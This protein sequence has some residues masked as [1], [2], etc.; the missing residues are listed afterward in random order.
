M[1]DKN[2]AHIG[3]IEVNLNEVVRDPRGIEDIVSEVLEE[4]FIESRYRQFGAW[5]HMFPDAAD[6]ADWDSALLYRYPRLYTYSEDGCSDCELGPCNLSESTGRCGLS[7]ESWQGRMS[8]RKACRGCASQMEV[9]HEIL[10][11]AIKVWDEGKEVSF[12]KVM[13]ISDEVPP[14]G[15]LTGIH[16]KTLGDLN[17]VQSY[18]ETQMVKLLWASQAGTGSAAAFEGMAMHAGSVLMAAQAVSE[19]VKVSCYDFITAADQP[20]IELDNWPPATTDGGWASIEAEKPTIALLGD[21]FLPAWN[22]INYMKENELT[23]QIEICSIGAAG[24]DTARFYSR[25]RVIA[26][27]AKAE[28]A[29]R[30]GVFDVVLAT[31]GCMAL[32]LIGE[33]KRVDAKLVWVSSQSLGDLEDRTAQPVDEIVDALIGGESAVWL[34]DV[35]KAGEVAVKIA[36]KAK[37][38]GSYILSD[39]EA[40]AEA[41]KCQG[42]CDLCFS[43]CP[44][45]LPISRAVEQLEKGNWEGFSEVEKGCYFCAK[46]ENS[47]PS[48]VKLRDIIVATE[49]KR[50]DTDK[51]VMRAGRGVLPLTELLQSAFAV[52][53]GNAPGI[54]V[55]LGCGNAPQEEIAWIGYELT[56]RNCIVI[57]AGCGAAEIAR[58]QNPQNKFIS[59]EFVSSVEARAF[60]NCGSCSAT[61]LASTFYMIMNSAG[62]ISH[63]ASMPEIA[64]ASFRS[65]MTL[66][67]WGALTDRMYAIGAAYARLGYKVVVGPASGLEWNRYAMGNRHDRSR[68]WVYHSEDGS[69][70]ETEPAPEHFIV[71][72]ETKEEA[73]TMLS[74]LFMSPSEFRESRA[75]HL[76]T[77]IELYQI[78]YDQLPD[79]W[80]LLVRSH[81]EMPTRHR[82]K[83]LKMLREQY[84]WETGQGRVQKAKN[85]DG[86]LMTL[87]ELAA[88]YGMELGVFHSRLHR[89]LPRAIRDISEP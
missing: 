45:T 14:I 26:P 3:P 22:A 64:D 43:S 74:R 31:T 17:K 20:L 80:N 8:L 58:Y 89:L 16:V 84:G 60:V 23:D 13:T 70:R 9:A 41:T 75:T 76:D 37:R 87:E 38:K 35:S 34:R 30:N 88:C 32:D 10:D 56:R 62:G 18:C 83:M 2:I 72:V 5:L 48:G 85:R 6:I 27:M 19:M 59:Q 55:M 44:N 52:A 71:P 4:D 49:R 77:M 73:I 12:G 50:A 29:I 63:Y 28:K 40:I 53:W 11:E 7:L 61:A 66:L 33:V 82:L 47:C 79:D 21:N 54:V 46:C 68:W 25:V 86:D 67:L 39:D 81:L 1:E 15:I 36:Q 65:G 69:K 78:F 24:D 51:F 42:D 57:T